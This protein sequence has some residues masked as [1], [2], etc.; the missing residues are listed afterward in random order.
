MRRV[1]DLDGYKFFLPDDQW[2]M[3]RASGTEPVLRIYGESSTA[4]IADRI[5]QATIDTIMQ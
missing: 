5:I 2:V 1:E 4:E 3:I